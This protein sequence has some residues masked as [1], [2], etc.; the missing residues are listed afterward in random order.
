MPGFVTESEGYFKSFNGD[1]EFY[2]VGS[3]ANHP[4]AI[5]EN[6]REKNGLLLITP[7][8]ICRI[9]PDIA[10]VLDD[11]KIVQAAGETDANWN[12]RRDNKSSKDVERIISDLQVILV[13]IAS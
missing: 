8:Q 9:A 1:G 5:T 10:V 6:F 12:S 11:G 3:V 13:A 4:I 7:K 2:L